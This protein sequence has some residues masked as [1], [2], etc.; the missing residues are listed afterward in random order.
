MQLPSLTVRAS[1]LEPGVTWTATPLGLSRS[2]E[3]GPESVTPWTD[4][5]DMRVSFDPTRF[6][7]HRRTL[8]LHLAGANV[9]IVSTHYT[10]IG[11]FDDR[12][13]AWRALVREIAGWMA[14]ADPGA[15]ARIGKAS[16]A[17]TPWVALAVAASAVLCMGP[18]GVGLVM[19]VWFTQGGR[20]REWQAANAA[21]RV[22]LDALTEEDL[23]G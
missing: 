3:N 23:G 18:V 8:Q 11:A 13:A 14:L 7:P 21:R 5:R 15:Q 16:A 10:G 17:S 20:I 9:R 2:P 22:P 1:A 4:V 12:G 6:D 19:V